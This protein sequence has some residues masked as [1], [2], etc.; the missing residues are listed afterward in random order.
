MINVEAHAI[1]TLSDGITV[2]VLTTIY[3]MNK[4]VIEND[5]GDIRR[6]VVSGSTV[7][8]YAGRMNPF[9]RELTGAAVVGVQYVTFYTIQAKSLSY[10][11][12]AD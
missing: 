8:D 10:S 4:T 7:V 12:S 2:R 5:I 6:Y 1:F 9:L 11:V 3:G